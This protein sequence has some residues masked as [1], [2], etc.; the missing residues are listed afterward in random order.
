MAKI[1]L[2]FA[3]S[4][5]REAVMV[6]FMFDS[7]DQALSIIANG[8]AEDFFMG[9]DFY[10]MALYGKP[11]PDLSQRKEEVRGIIYSVDW[12]NGRLIEAETQIPHLI[13]DKRKGKEGFTNLGFY[14]S[15]P[16][17]GIVFDAVYDIGGRT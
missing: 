12:G 13:G 15:N 1:T 4:K 10:D 9:T 14:D 2:S 17:L 5:I 11:N 8:I 7:D 16:F 6:A 3:E